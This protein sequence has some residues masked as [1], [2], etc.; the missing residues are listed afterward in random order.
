ML[1]QTNSYIVPKEKRV[2]H[3]RLMRRFRQV[4][5]RLGCD[6]FEVHEQAGPNWANGEAS[7]RV[8]QIMR[9]RDRKHH[10]A[11]Q[12][13]ERTDPAAQQLIAEFCALVNFQYQ[14]QQGFFAVGFYNSIISPGIPRGRELE[15]SPDA[16][17]EEP[18]PAEQATETQAYAA[19]ELAEEHE[20]G[21]LTE[22]ETTPELE[23]AAEPGNEEAPPEPLSEEELMSELSGESAPTESAI[24]EPVAPTE[25][26]EPESSRKSSFFKRRK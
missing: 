1:L 12:A 26:P 9:F 17:P 21:H 2:E 16:A 25:S 22:G 19:Q 18:E 24:E 11:L 23:A 4:L 15:E 8:V 3:A 6:D 13:A 14:Q 10:A 7:P 5:G 20:P